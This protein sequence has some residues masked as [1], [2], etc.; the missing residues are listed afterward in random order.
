VIAIADC[1]I[2]NLGSVERAFRA[3]AAGA[4]R[5]RDARLTSDPAVVAAADA[6]VLPGDGAFGAT[7]RALR[8]RG[9]DRAIVAARERGAWIVGVC[10]GMQVLFDAGEERGEHAGLALLRG[11]VR[12]LPDTVRLPH[13][14]WNSLDFTAPT[15]L[16][17]GL[18]PAPFVYFVHSFS[19][20]AAPG[21]TIAVATYGRTFPAIVQRGRLVGMQFHP[22][23]SQAPGRRLL[24]NLLSQIP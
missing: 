5:P 10:V 14:G 21:D 12:R 8:E 20:E 6:V 16:A 7:M 24:T 2:G 9:L 3:C 17:D 13:M 11:R 22:E 1:G 23:K 18:G 4:A 15:P 19:C